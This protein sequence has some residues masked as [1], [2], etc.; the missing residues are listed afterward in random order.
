MHC[1]DNIH[2]I[3]CT[4]LHHTTKIIHKTYAIQMRCTAP[5]TYT[6]LHYTSH[7]RIIHVTHMDESRIF[8]TGDWYKKVVTL[9][10]LHLGTRSFRFVCLLQCLVVAVPV[11]VCVCLL[12]CVCACCSV[13]VPV[14]VSCGACVPV[15]VCLC[16]SQCLVVCVSVVVCVCLLQC[17]CACCSVCVPVAVSCGVCVPT[18][19]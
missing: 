8:T 6:T 15:A 17:V 13:C 7:M 9:G 11:A 1:T 16:L 3:H 5:T 12:Q 18:H 10:L 4:T 2:Y 19:M 14:A